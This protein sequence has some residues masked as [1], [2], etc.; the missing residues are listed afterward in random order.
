MVQQVITAVGYYYP[1]LV[2]ATSK[3]LQK[4]PTAIGSMPVDW[5]AVVIFSSSD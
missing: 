4:I 5:T 3:T 1:C 2:I